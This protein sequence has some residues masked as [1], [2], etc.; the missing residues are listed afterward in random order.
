M[1]RLNTLRAPFLPQ[2]YPALYAATGN[3]DVDLPF[4]EWLIQRRN[5]FAPNQASRKFCIPLT[6]VQMRSIYAGGR[7]DNEPGRLNLRG[8]F[9]FLTIRFGG[10]FRRLFVAETVE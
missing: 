5:V 1:G 2:F 8:K 3:S 7:N 9:Y 6:R 10:I 4:L